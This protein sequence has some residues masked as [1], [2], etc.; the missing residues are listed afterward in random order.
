MTKLYIVRHGQSTANLGNVFL[1]QHNLDLTELGV[2]QA[3]N[4]AKY[5]KDKKVDAIYSSDLTRAVNTAEQTAKLVGMPIIT[6]VGLREIDGGLWEELHFDTL[7]EKFY[8]NF[9]A[10]TTD[11]GNS[12]IDGGESVAELY[13]RFIGAVENIAKINDGKTVFI[14]SHATCIRCFGA[15][16]MGFGL[17]KM[18]E[19]PWPNNASVT[20]VDYQNGEFNMIKY[21]Y[22]D[23]MG[24]IKSGL[25]NEY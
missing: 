14:F 24:D 11:I 9:V 3:K 1:G 18:Q 10:F 22:D 12:K 2:M 16:C 5:L 23:F 7:K 20:E 17:E 8:D 4:T 13:H 15:Y 19:L 21:G 25:P 6:D